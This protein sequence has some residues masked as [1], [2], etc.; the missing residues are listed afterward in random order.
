MSAVLRSSPPRGPLQIRNRTPSPVKIETEATTALE[1]TMHTSPKQP[2]VLPLNLRR[3]PS[4]TRAIE[5]NGVSPSRERSNASS[6]GLERE[7]SSSSTLTRPFAA[8]GPS[9]PL[10]PR[11]PTVKRTRSLAPLRPPISDG[12][13]VSGT[14]RRVSAG[15]ERVPL[16]DD[17]N[18]SPQT[19]QSFL[20]VASMKAKRARSVEEMTPRKR[21][22]DRHSKTIT[23]L[24]TD[25]DEETGGNY[26]RTPSG[27]KRDKE[28]LRPSVR[29]NGVVTPLSRQTDETPTFGM[30]GIEPDYSDEKEHIKR[31]ILQTRQVKHQLDRLSNSMGSKCATSK[32]LQTVLDESSASLTRSPP[33]RKLSKHATSTRDT[34]LSSRRTPSNASTSS[35]TDAVDAGF[36]Q[37]WL[38]RSNATIEHVLAS[39]AQAEAEK[40][41]L[42]GRLENAQEQVDMVSLPLCLCV[43]MSNVKL[44]VNPV[45]SRHVKSRACRADWSEPQT[46]TIWP[47]L[48]YKMSRPSSRLYM[49]LSTWSLTAYSTMP[50]FLRPRRSRP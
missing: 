47:R 40:S 33:S 34:S 3:T 14:G 38:T 22:Y 50:A 9:R 45:I 28:P 36:V 43:V 46:S 21:S 42:S 32:Q 37:G 31:A 7:I 2:S 1:A 29:S 20:G 16:K 26:K 35:K 6:P 18:P 30:D 17:D 49:K 13:I 24:E 8:S 25:E 10:G 41:E 27:S 39:L 44:K 4:P 5:R 11:E 15:R 19:A 23:Q 12:R 48:R